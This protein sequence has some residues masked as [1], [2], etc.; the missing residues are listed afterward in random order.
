MENPPP[1]YKYY[2]TKLKIKILSLTTC[3]L[4]QQNKS[5]LECQHC[6]GTDPIDVAYQEQIPPP[7][8]VISPRT[9]EAT[10]PPSSVKKET[11]RKEKHH[12]NS[13]LS[14]SAS[15]HMEPVT[16]RTCAYDGCEKTL[17]RDNTTGYC[18]K[19]SRA[20]PKYKPTPVP[21]KAPCCE[22][23]TKGFGTTELC[24][25]CACKE[26]SKK[27]RKPESEKKRVVTLKANKAKRKLKTDI[28]K[29]RTAEPTQY[30]PIKT[31]KEPGCDYVLYPKNKNGYCKEHSR[32]KYTL[33]KR[34]DSHMELGIVRLTLDFGEY[35]E[36]LKA[37]RAEAKDQIRTIE[38]QAMFI[39]KSHL[40]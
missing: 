30:P 26:N 23:M 14:P 2:C 35:L 18:R 4:R 24:Q 27:S 36:I 1:Q 37:L 38:Q 33:P 29:S 13:R 19:H 25:G 9:K 31:C 7:K 10:T 8:K 6:L 17:R 28:P 12:N 32:G 15:E 16:Y 20:A 21:C 5:M 39:I 3:E 40:T 22:N 11:R 34:A